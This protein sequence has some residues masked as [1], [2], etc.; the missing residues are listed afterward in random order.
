M[1]KFFLEILKKLLVTILFAM[2]MFLASYCI[3]T[4][5][6]PPKFANMKKG[7][8]NLQG[9][10]KQLN[11]IRDSQLE[12]LSQMADDGASVVDQIDI[13]KLSAS[14]PSTPSTHANTDEAELRYQQALLDKIKELEARISRLENQSR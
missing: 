9:Q 1:K 14:S 11:K 6:F 12:K 4:G 5:E 3:V 13:S 2:L 7:I 10:V 8:L